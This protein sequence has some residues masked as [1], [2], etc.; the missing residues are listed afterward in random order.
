MA[1]ISY[2]KNSGYLDRFDLL[3]LAEFGVTI[4]IIIDEFELAGDIPGEGVAEISSPSSLCS[5][6]RF[7]NSRHFR[8]MLR[9]VS[10]EK[11]GFIPMLL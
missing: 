5:F 3:M 6:Y 8:I 10:R 4:G 2:L 11:N 9:I 1:V 7:I